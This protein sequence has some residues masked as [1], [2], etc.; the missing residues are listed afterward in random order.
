MTSY[1]KNAVAVWQAGTAFTVRAGSGHTL[2]TDGSAQIAASPMELILAGLAGCAGADVIDILRKKRQNVTAFEVRVHGD[3]C[4]E[5]P[6]VYTEIEIVF[7][8]TGHQVD[9]DAVRRAIELSEAKYC[10]VSAMLRHTAQVNCRYEIHAADATA[11]Q[12]GGAAGPTKE[13]SI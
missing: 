11:A 6:R 13:A 4:V 8:V 10:S 2:L 7:V 3:R 9:A 1:A 5:H 12:G